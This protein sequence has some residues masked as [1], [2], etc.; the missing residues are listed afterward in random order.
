MA[1]TIRLQRVGATK[2]PQYRMVVAE[3]SVRRDG[4]IVE[5]LGH[6]APRDTNAARNLTVKLDRVDYWVGKG[7]QMS[8]T[9]RTLIK[10]AKKAPKAA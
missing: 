5:L 7:A 8:D 2:A 10:K 3:R 6:Y 4:N 1:L 9:A